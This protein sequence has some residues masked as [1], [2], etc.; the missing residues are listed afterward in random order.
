L[1]NN[2]ADDL[3]VT[4]NGNYSF[5]RKLKNNSSY[6]IT[7]LTQPQNPP[8]TC[9]V[10]NGSGKI[11]SNNIT[12][13][14]ISCATNTVITPVFSP[15][16]G[17]Y[18]SQQTISITT[19]TAGATIYYTT[20]GSTPTIASSVYSTPFSIWSVA[21][22]TIKAYAVFAGLPDSP[23]VTGVYSYQTIKTGQ[24]ISFAAGD[25]A[26]TAQ[27]VSPSYTGPTQHPTYTSDYTTTDNYTGLVWRSCSEGQ[28]G[29]G[30][31]G[32]ASTSSFAAGS[33]S[34]S[35]LNAMNAGNGYA[36]S[37]NWR[38]PTMR[39]LLTLLDY[40]LAVY[41]I[42]TAIFPNTA[43]FA[44]WSSTPYPPNG[45]FAWYTDYTNGNSFATTNT[46]P[47]HSR[48]VIAPSITD[49]PNS[50]TDNGD[51]TVK[52]NRTGLTWQKCSQGQNNDS[53]CSGAITTSTWANALTYCNTLGLAGKTWRLPNINEI[54]TL[55]DF[56]I[57]AGAT[58]DLTTF[59]S[60]PSGS[61]G[62]YYWSSSTYMANTANAWF[63]NFGGPAFNSYAFDQAKGTLS[64]VRCVTGP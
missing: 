29:A 43:N 5:S 2:L 44:Y 8:Q 55:Y 59:P 40:S 20:D 57:A 10:S 48:C 3:T 53:T 1:Q 27:G 51:G 18:A 35:A 23:V 19:A 60:T 38:L 7:V 30:C 46:N 9:I 17:I 47:Y 15:T 22:K 37:T 42:N 11:L 54:G 13:I 21:G 32:G 45:G 50:Y 25:D 36:G 14:T 58:I 39:E 56:T 6:N 62:G 49:A 4:A 16:P 64:N 24:T 12:N 61:P 28:T 26:A 41:T 63:L 34:C 33:A 52:E 31:A